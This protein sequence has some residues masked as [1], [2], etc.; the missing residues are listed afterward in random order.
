GQPQAIEDEIIRINTEARP[1][2]LQ[3]ALLIP[4]LASLLG[5]LV[6]FRMMRLPDPVSSGAAEGFALG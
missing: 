4:I 3:V 1:M 2:A 5:L 6:S